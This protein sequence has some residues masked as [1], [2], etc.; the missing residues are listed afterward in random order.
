MVN[1]HGGSPCGWC[2]ARRSSASSA[3]SSSTGVSPSAASTRRRSSPVRSATT[4]ATVASRRI[5]R[6]PVALAHRA[7]RRRDAAR[8]RRARSHAVRC[9]SDPTARTSCDPAIATGWRLDDRAAEPPSAPQRV[10]QEGDAELDERPGTRG[11][12]RDRA[13]SF[14]RIPARSTRGSRP[15]AARPAGAAASRA[16]CCPTCRGTRW[17]TGWDRR[18]RRSAPAPRSGLDDVGRARRRRSTTAGR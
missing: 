16:R 17:R 13:T 7:A 14:G 10:E 18:P 8:R 3:C 2:R 11:R 4:R 15:V 1:G 6:E 5:G 9:S 12:A